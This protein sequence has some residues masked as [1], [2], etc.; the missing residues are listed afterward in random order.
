[1]SFSIMTGGPQRKTSRSLKSGTRRVNAF[2]VDVA[3]FA[4][5]VRVARDDV[6]NCQVFIRGE[7]FEFT[8]KDN[9]VGGFVAVD[10]NAVES[11]ILSFDHGPQGRDAD[12]AGDVEALMDCSE[13]S[14]VTVRPGDDD[15]GA[16]GEVRQ[17]RSVIP[18]RLR[19]NAQ[20]AVLG[21]HG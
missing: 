7:G 16:R 13:R 21:E 19:R 2:G 8:F 10:E 12:A 15:G 11:R 6:M 20:T 14:E 5:E 4:L 9:V 18:D 17:F 3:G 1:M